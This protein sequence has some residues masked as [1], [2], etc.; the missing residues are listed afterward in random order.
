MFSILVCFAVLYLLVG[1][2]VIY[3]SFVQL[4]SDCLSLR[5]LCVEMVPSM[6]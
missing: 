6:L 5:T 2:A 3:V 1:I 4:A